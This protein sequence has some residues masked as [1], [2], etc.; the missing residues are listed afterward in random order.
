MVGFGHLGAV[1]VYQVVENVVNARLQLVLLEEGQH[2]LDAQAALAALLRPAQDLEDRF[3]GDHI[4]LTL[5]P[6]HGR[7]RRCRRAC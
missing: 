6:Q 1:V 3:F 4:H 7:A 5:R 2:L